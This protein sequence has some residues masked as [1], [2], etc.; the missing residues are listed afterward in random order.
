MSRRDLQT[1]PPAIAAAAV[2]VWTITAL[3]QQPFKSGTDVVTVPVTVT[4]RSGTERIRD[5]TAVDFR[6]FENGDEQR[7]SVF[8]RERR[9]IS[10]CITLDS[11]FSMTAPQQALAAAAVTRMLEGLEPDDE[12]SLVVF[13]GGSQ[14]LLG[15]TPLKA[16]DGKRRRLKIETTNRNFRVR[17]RDS[18]VAEK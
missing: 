6:L 5:L 3:G 10:L 15:Y 1:R 13:A 9:P 8:N 17:H 4:N 2:L 11:S 18:Y 16:F 12:V 14:Y 7:V